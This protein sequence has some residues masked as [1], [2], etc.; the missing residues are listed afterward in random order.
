MKKLKKV[1]GLVCALTCAVSSAG[2]LS[3]CGGDGGNSQE[4]EIF[5]T[6]AGYGISFITE[7][8]NQF[9]QQQWVKDKYPNLVVKWNENDPANYSATSSNAVDKAT[10]IGANTADLIFTTQDIADKTVV[11]NGNDYYIEDLKDVYFGAIP[12]D[13]YYDG[14]G[15][16]RYLKDKMYPDIWKEIGIL[17][18]RGSKKGQTSYYTMPAVNGWMGFVVNKDYVARYAGQEAANNLPKTTDELI[19]LCDD[20][21]DPNVGGNKAGVPII[22]CRNVNYW[23]S[24]MR[25]WWTQY[26]GMEGYD[27]FCNLQVGKRKGVDNWY[28]Q[29]RLEAVRTIATLIG[30]TDGMP[31]KYY[32]SNAH[33]TQSNA[34][35]TQQ[36]TFL[37]GEGA[38]MYN[39]DW[40]ENE[41]RQAQNGVTI[42]NNVVYLKSPVISAVVDKFPGVFTIRYD[43][44]DFADLTALMQEFEELELKTDA[45]KLEYILAK[46]G[47]KPQVAEGVDYG[48][49]YN[50]TLA[51][52]ADAQ[53]SYLIGLI[54]E[55]K[56]YATAKTAYDAQF[57]S[58]GVALT[59]K[60][61]D[62]IAAARKMEH[63]VDGQDWYIPAYADGKEIAKDFL[64]F[65]AT[66]L[67]TSIIMEK[68]STL[69]PFMVDDDLLNYIDYTPT[70]A[71][72]VERRNDTTYLPTLAAYQS[73]RLA[74]VRFLNNM[75]SIES[76]LSGSGMTAW[77]LF[78]N[79]IVYSEQ[80]VGEYISSAFPSI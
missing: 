69:S 12:G 80:K 10:A 52:Q 7:A 19:A 39:G 28:Q 55:G 74:H 20:I 48:S 17:N 67:G 18:V 16:G 70:L 58:A 46:L 41:T 13:T 47:N 1:I 56:D 33:S 34:Y 35:I 50:N 14:S 24:Q 61:Y 78:T 38:M 68:S 42:T 63:R 51:A 54:D 31:S 77:E 76:N 26:D 49:R 53:L 29:G 64:R 72:R 45:E 57:A 21:L 66:D 25:V 4:L 40:I 8:V 43:L 37:G 71:S 75:S 3:A 5:A 23:A 36:K 9:K 2:A 62:H 60:A 59:Q 79:E 22:G 6:R 65:M 27:N 44:D 11:L 32:D 15:E 73:Y 30:G